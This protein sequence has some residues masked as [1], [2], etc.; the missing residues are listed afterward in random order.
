MIQEHHENCI[1]SLLE[2]STFFMRLLPQMEFFV[3][4]AED[5][6]TCNL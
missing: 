1:V 2:K 3:V 6:L 5:E 4:V